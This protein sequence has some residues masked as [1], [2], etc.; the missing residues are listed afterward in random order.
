MFTV[1]L[2]KVFGVETLAVALVLIKCCWVAKCLDKLFYKTL[3]NFTIFFASQ[4][5]NS[6]VLD[7]CHT[8]EPNVNVFVPESFMA[9]PRKK[10]FKILV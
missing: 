9:L 5:S 10:M 8:F 1:Y 7:R 3:F 2:I 4:L 6:F